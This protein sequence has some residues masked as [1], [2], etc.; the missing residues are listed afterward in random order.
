MEELA[1]FRNL[2]IPAAILTKDGV[3]IDVNNAFEE[4]YK[5]S[6]EEVIGLP[7]ENLYAKEDHQKIKDAIAQCIDKGYFACETEMTR[8]DGTKLPVLLNFSSI[9]KEGEDGVHII[10]TLTD[11]SEL[12]MKD[13]DLKYAERYARALVESIPDFQMVIDLDGFVKDVNTGVEDRTGYLR[14]ELIGKNVRELPFFTKNSLKVLDKTLDKLLNNGEWTYAVD[15]EYIRK[16]GERRV[17]SLALT[18]IFVGDAVNELMITLRDVTPE[19]MMAEGLK[20][21]ISLF[22][23]TLSKAADGDLTV[24]VDLDKTPE[25]YRVI[26]ANIN[27]MISAISERE[28]ELDDQKA[29]LESLVMNIPVP[30]VVVDFDG[31]PIMSSEK[32]NELY[33]FKGDEVKDLSPKDVFLPEYL[34][35]VVKLLDDAKE[36]K[37]GS[38]EVMISD[39]NGNKIPVLISIGPVYNREGD[40]VNLVAVLTDIT[41]VKRANEFNEKVIENLPVGLFVYGKDGRCRYVNKDVS[42][43]LG[44]SKEEIIGKMADESSYV[45]ASGE[46]YMKEGTIDALKALWQKSAEGKPAT[47]L[48][49]L[50]TKD[51]RIKVFNGMDLPYSDGRICT[52]IDITDDFVRERE[53]R[54]AIEEIGQALTRMSEG[55]LTAGIDPGK[56]ADAYKPIAENINVFL[57]NMTK[58]VGDIIDRMQKTVRSAEEGS[59]AVNQMSTG[60]QQISSSAQQ[61]AS[62]SE[63]LSNIAVSV[64]SDLNESVKIFNDLYA[65]TEDAAK[66]MNEMTATSKDLSRDADEAREG[67]DEVIAK[68]K[69]NIELINGLNNAIKNI[70]KVTGKI[71]D[72]ADQTNLLAL[73]AAIEAA[74]AGEHGRGFAVVA[75]EVRKLAEESKRSTEEIE[76]I[77][78]EIRSASG[79]V[80]SSSKEMSSTSDKSSKL[81]KRVLDSFKEVVDSLDDLS[82]ATDRVRTLSRDGVDNLETIR[83]GM[84]EVASTSEEMAASSEETSAAIEEQTA[85]IA[86]LSETIESVKDYATSTYNAII[87]NFKTDET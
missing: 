71:K 26:G 25:E 53:L 23:D 55:D 6:R 51:G 11:V 40:I 87:S 17:G 69:E 54:E 15:I 59:D 56:I 42:R 75:D 20:D 5:R 35:I 2:P 74:R 10:C 8:N 31:T 52:A 37:Y 84:N 80:I 81:I 32:H 30:L 76:D 79:E 33:G 60:M 41:E 39:K 63:N 72:I 70:G 44:Y 61:V 14:D 19:R 18:E 48:V 49:P 46:P 77:T 82:K 64:Q 66:K 4:F 1:L 28:K 83:E 27:K 16:D 65:Y 50:R 38:A 78:N 68:I 29:Y 3:R 36:G 62:G 13:E 43:V 9:K 47:G 58:I 45:C 86:Q 24:R 12:K 57:E 7:L 73:N 22:R 67:V 21:A 34:P 85:A